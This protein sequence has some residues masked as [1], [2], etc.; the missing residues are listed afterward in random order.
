M[1]VP[2]IYDFPKKIEYNCKP[3]KQLKGHKKVQK[4]KSGLEKVG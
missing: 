4:V 3:Q 2:P 1:Y